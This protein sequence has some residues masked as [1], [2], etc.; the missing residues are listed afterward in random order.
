M[1][2]TARVV[3][4]AGVLLALATGLPVWAQ[5]AGTD[6]AQ[7]ASAD[8]AQQPGHRIIPLVPVRA[9][10]ESSLDTKSAKQG[11]AV[12]AK[13]QASAQIPN[14]PTLR[15]NT[16][17]IGH[18]DQ[19]QA[20]VQ[21][22]VSSLLVTFDQAQLKKDELL[23]IKVTIMAIAPPAISPMADESPG[24]APGGGGSAYQQVPMPQQTAVPEDQRAQPINLPGE[25]GQQLRWS[26]Q[27]IPGV[28]L[29]SDIHKMT[30]ATFLAQRRNVQ[31]PEGTQM[32]V[33][34][35]VVP[36]DVRL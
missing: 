34:I 1:C 15:R 22:S 13:L 33:V 20:S 24:A 26:L 7:N 10:L 17:L 16:V 36:K 3:F 31:I 6:G 12:R 21:H 27:G 14:G 28:T 9:V 25:A 5:N 19:V 32:V 2:A 29:Q 11:D 30:S 18:I 8:A 4:A 23:P 35:G